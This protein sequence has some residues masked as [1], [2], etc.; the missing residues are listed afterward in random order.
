MM[1][2]G[3][4]DHHIEN[5]LR[6]WLEFFTH[7][8][9][10]LGAALVL[11][12]VAAIGIFLMWNQ[13]RKLKRELTVAI[14]AVESSGANE[15]EFTNNFS[16]VDE[17]LKKLPHI[18]RPWEEFTETLIP[19]LDAVDDPDYR[20]FRNT[21]RPENFFRASV[22]TNLIKPWIPGEILIGVGLMLT[23]FGLVAALTIAG[24]AFVDGGDIKATLGVLISTAGAK[25]LASIGGLSGSILI[26]L[27]QRYARNAVNKKLFK[28]CD[29]LEERLYYASAERIMADQ[30]GHMKRQTRNLEELGN[31][32]AVAIGDRI[33]NAMS[34]M[35]N[36]L[37]EAMSPMAQS[38][39]NLRDAVSDSNKEGLTELVGEFKR[40]LTGAG[41]ESMNQ[42]AAQLE[43]VSTIMGT[44]VTS[45][46]QTTTMLQESLTGSAQQAAT[47]LQQGSD[48]FAETLRDAMAG[49]VTG[50]TALQ[51][52]LNNVVDKLTSGADQFDERLNRQR[53]QMAEN[54][55]RVVDSMNQAIS[56]KTQQ[57]TEQMG[58]KINQII[59]SSGQQAANSLESWAGSFVEKMEAPIS[60]IRGS[61]EDWSSKTSVVTQSLMQINEA[62]DRHK[63]SIENSSVMLQS[64]G[65][66]MA[67]S[68]RSVSDATQP[69][70]TAAEAAA[71]ATQSLEH[72]TKESSDG[73]LEFSRQIG[74][75]ISEN[76][77]MLSALKSTWEEQAGQ[78]QGADQ[79]LEQAFAQITRNLQSTLENMNH[80]VDK[81]NRSFADAL[82]S[83]GGIVE[84]L[85]D[86]VEDLS[87]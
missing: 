62:L 71:R 39:D 4:I 35:P 76:Q 30:Y 85:Q 10:A 87:R 58:G 2:A 44:T 55:S 43:N 20:V 26:S 79:A 73:L 78:L 32:I 63:Q 9:Y 29:S 13:A 19:P 33:E 31:S 59:E 28:L 77:A 5:Q 17:K 8:Y 72:M 41:E 48:A 45:L 7:Y 86:A 16:D 23:F 38:I 65:Q 22:T 82:Q 15:E 64:S 61:L 75:A 81:T 54:M 11:I 52:T 27:Y 40:E 34:N 70:K 21:Q 49:M 69:L 84:G 36:L 46:Q 53:D 57:A 18:K 24:P 56:Q 14:E 12:G 37:G 83:L 67:E 25:F 80:F 42:M 66:K 51:D 6:I 68:A 3:Q 47:Q 74:S 50:Q 60:G 1:N